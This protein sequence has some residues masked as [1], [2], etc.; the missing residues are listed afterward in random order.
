MPTI[1]FCMTTRGT[2]PR[3]RGLLELVRPHV[4]EVV[5]ALDRKGN[6]DALDVCADLVD[7]KVTFDYL[8]PPCRMIGWLQHQCSCDWLL[9]LDDDE[10][11]SRALLDALPELLADR[12][13]THYDLT[14][15]WLYRDRDTWIL[16][17]PWYPDYHTRLVRNIPGIWHF[18]GLM[19][20]PAFVL[21]E[22]RLLDLP[23]YHADL[24]LQPVDA[25]RRKAG[26]YE[27][28]R[29]DHVA[30]G[31]PVNAIYAPE[32][33]D[34][35]VTESVPA[36]DRPVLRGVLEA[37]APPAPS[38]REEEVRH[39]TVGEIDAYNTTRAV[40]DG[41]Y[42]ARI[43]FVRPVTQM[44]VGIVRHQEVLVENLGDERWPWG[45]EGEP[46]IRLGYR[47]R[48]AGDDGAVVAEG[49]RTPFTET[50]VP[51]AR[52]MVRLILRSPPRPGDYVLEVD[53]VHEHV[54]WFECAA[55]LPVRVGIP[56][57]NGSRAPGG[58]RR[59]VEQVRADGLPMPAAVLQYR[60]WTAALDA[61]RSPLAD[62]R[63]WV[64]FGAQEA[65]DAAVQAGMRACEFGAGGSTLYL[66]DRGADLVTI[67]WD[68]DWAARVEAAVAPERRSAWTLELVAPEAGADGATPTPDPSDP[69]AYLS[70]SPAFASH[71]F[72]A[73]VEAVDRFADASFDLVLVSGRARPS[74]L[75]HA[76]AK[77]RPGGL[78]V[79]DHAERPWYAPALGL[80][81]GGEWA[82]EDHRG[83]GPY[84]ERFWTTAV[85]RRQP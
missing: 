59:Y 66:L 76:L 31:V 61:D 85:F 40:S 71:S 60:R 79:F 47:W 10:I 54:R 52:S 63:A 42:R 22:R 7:R 38:G 1:S 62:R 28:L 64:T 51:G 73:Y 34:D 39:F 68:A 83:P 18:T 12:R 37:P 78:L 48:A 11:P 26:I 43:E 80:V 3:I 50:V 44:P 32:D 72:R 16:S 35:L 29:P 81:D 19:H 27:R 41:A 15:R 74:A 70:A 20:D 9:R 33:W 84:A 17:P 82:R 30:E 4:D 77:V 67:E 14:E 69:Q 36:E 8:A 65:L 25:R 75:V 2:L 58:L 46:P 21:G 56:S 24:L 23:I 5:I 55:R 57:E 13:P 6:L 53:V 49:P 45:L